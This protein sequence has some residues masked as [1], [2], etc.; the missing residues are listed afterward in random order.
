MSG[1][2][3]E[4]YFLKLIY[5]FLGVLGLPCCTQAFSS[6]SELGGATLYHGAWASRCSGLPRCRAQ[7]LGV[8]A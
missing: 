3:N 7:A 1:S 6:C 2:V 5:I 4:C 8:Q